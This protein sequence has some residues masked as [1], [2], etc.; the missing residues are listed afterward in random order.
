MISCG[1]IAKMHSSEIYIVGA[2]EPGYARGMGMNPLATFEDALKDAEKH[3][4][5]NPNILA[6]PKAFKKKPVHLIMKDEK[7]PT[8]K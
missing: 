6:L 3:V 5:K 7:I 8:V 2:Y 1:H 4:G